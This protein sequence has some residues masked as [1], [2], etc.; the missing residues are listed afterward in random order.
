METEQHSSKPVS[1]PLNK[2]E[3]RNYLETNEN[4]NAAPQN[5]QDV[6]KAVLRGT[7]IA[8]WGPQ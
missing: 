1:Q 3:I 2:E 7:F 8:T 5:L 6:T 4:G